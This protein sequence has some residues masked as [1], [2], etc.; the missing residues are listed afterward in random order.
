MLRFYARVG[1]GLHS[2]LLPGFGRVFD[3]QPVL[4]DFLKAFVPVLLLRILGP[5]PGV[6]HA[7]EFPLSGMVVLAGVVIGHVFPLYF[8]F[9]GG[10]G[11]AALAG[12]WFA[13]LPL[14]C[15]AAVLVFAAVVGIFRRVSLGA[16][17]VAVFLPVFYCIRAAVRFGAVDLLPAAALLLSGI[18]ILWTHRANIGRLLRGTEPALGA[19]AGGGTGGGKDVK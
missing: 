7:L 1:C 17:T 3:W 10:K 4:I 6:F 5:L 19:G 16:V 15:A 9:R 8:S 11:V 13:I 2:V 18:F 12:G 14:E